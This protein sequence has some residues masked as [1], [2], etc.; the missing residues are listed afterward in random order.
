MSVENLVMEYSNMLFKI[1][2]VMLCNEQDAQDVLQDTFCRY[3]EKAV[4]FHDREHEKAWL[5]KVATNRC[6]D[7]HRQRMRH[8]CT[9]LEK[10]TASC[11]MPEQSEV[12]EALVRLPDKL[13]IVI[14]LHYIEGYQ[15]SEIAEMLGISA[16]AVK[17]R[18]QRGR[19]ELRLML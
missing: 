1:C 7:I 15:C 14:Y 11:E 18:M 4:D 10:V 17:K 13:K 12:L 2:M 19:E 16:Q 3:M 5:I 9:D 8:P 6:R